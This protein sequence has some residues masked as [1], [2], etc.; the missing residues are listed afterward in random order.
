MSLGSEVQRFRGALGFEV[1]GFRGVGLL[2]C[3]GLGFRGFGCEVKGFRVECCRWSL[4]LC[5]SSGSRL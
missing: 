5:R 4:E 1:Q 2:G 3:E